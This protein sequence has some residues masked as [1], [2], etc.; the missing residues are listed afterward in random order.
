MHTLL[1]RHQIVL[2]EIAG[3][4]L[5]AVSIYNFAAPSKF[6]MTGLFGISLILYRLFSIPIGLSSF[7]M[8][9]PIAIVCYRLLGQKFFFRSIR[10]MVISSIMTDYVAPLIP[11]YN[12]NRLLAAICVGVIGGIGFALIY[13]QNS[14]TGGADFIIMA[15]KAKKPH[16]P[17]GNIT[18]TLAM[19]IIILTWVIFR[20]GDGVI[21]GLII[22]YIAGVVI[23][24]TMYGINSG[25]FTMIVTE[26]GAKVAAAIDHCCHRGSTIINALGGYRQAPRQTVFCA[27]NNKQMYELE[28]TVKSADP[29]SFMVIWDSNEVRGNGFHVITPGQKE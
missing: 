24:K 18:F 29:N 20:D 7:I 25:K 8:N 4:F 28:K 5:V 13:M 9:I 16:W 2:G 12:G 14:S 26:D 27:C 1:K 11:L 10:C 17:L 15:L 21:Y 3:S 22:N 23:N 19:A 6:P